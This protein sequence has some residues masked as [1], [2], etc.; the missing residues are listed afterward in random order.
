MKAEVT[1]TTA[2]LLREKLP[3]DLKVVDVGYDEC[4]RYLIRVYRYRQLWWIFGYWQHI[5]VVSVGYSI[6]V[7]NP[8]DADLFCGFD[9]PVKV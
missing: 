4:P 1:Q 8:E 3:N 6:Y 5:A 2:T 9:L 7:N